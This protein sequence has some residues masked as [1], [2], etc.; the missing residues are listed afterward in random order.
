MKN[1]RAAVIHFLFTAATFIVFSSISVADSLTLT[2]G[3]V[4]KGDIIT[5][6]PTEVTMNCKVGK[7]YE[8]KKFA[9]AKIK[10]VVDD[11]PKVSGSGEPK[12]PPTS[13]GATPGGSASGG[14]ASKKPPSGAGTDPAPSESSDG[15][16]ADDEAKAAE[17]A[18][19]GDSLYARIKAMR[20]S[21]SSAAE[22]LQAVF[23]GFPANVLKYEIAEGPTQVKLTD[24]AAAEG[25]VIVQVKVDIEIDKGKYTIWCKGAKEAFSAIATEK[26][27]ISWNPK[28][29]GAVKISK[30]PA[31]LGKNGEIDRNVSYDGK[32]FVD[33][34]SLYMSEKT[35]KAEHLWIESSSWKQFT[36]QIDV[37]SKSVSNSKG[38]KAN[39]SLRDGIETKKDLYF[40]CLLSS[41]GGSLDVFGIPTEVMATL[42]D[43]EQAPLI[44]TDLLDEAGETIA[45]IVR[46]K[47]D[48]VTFVKEASRAK[49]LLKKNGAWW[50]AAP[51][52][53]SQTWC[54]IT[55]FLNGEAD[56]A[57]IFSSRISIPFWFSITLKD[58]PN[59]KKVDVQL[60]DKTAHIDASPD[61]SPGGTTPAKPQPMPTPAE[62]ASPLSWAE[63][64]EQNPDPK[65][66]TDADF[67][68]RITETKLPWRV[69]D[70]ASGIEML[71]VPPGKFVMGMSPGDKEAR[72]NEKP[73]HEVTITKAFYLG[74]TEVTQMQWMKVMGKNPSRFQSGSRESLIAKYIE[75]GLTTPQAK[76]KATKETSNG[77]EQSENPVE[78]VSWGDCQ[79]FCTKTGMKL[80][81]E[82][83]WE[84]ACR[85]GVLEPRY[86]ELDRIA[87]YDNNLQRA[88]H[89]VAQKA[90]N[91]LGFYDM[92]GNVGEFCLDI[93]GD[94][95]YK[96]CAEGVIDPTG[97][98]EGRFAQPRVL[99]G[100][101]WINASVACRASY[102]GPDARGDQYDNVGCRFARTAD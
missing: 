53:K 82:A 15:A 38:S 20:E 36:Q 86:G 65:V 56:R 31:P 49:A 32:E 29:G 99:R 40:V 57:R 48:P 95:Y 92:I 11:A 93:Y 33:C 12:T 89:S 42:D 59:C 66:V 102:R 62:T 58:L 45:S 46:P 10:S 1:S 70:K 13:T 30:K 67:L 72:D 35:A 7:T 16:K 27:T 80:P 78:N 5:N 8:V 52:L 24:Q 17:A 23:E 77:W 71:L 64:L 69:M 19:D 74:R 55:P 50:N 76:E 28:K 101:S 47:D 18:G 98:A 81:T 60:G 85:A 39:K 3:T 96:S 73:A 91:A 9:R 14:T 61:A 22:I 43:L 25:D 37:M 26:K 88:T 75:E 6:T 100:G 87:W 63:V 21:K 2:D 84:F 34:F 97:P 54:L 68:K 83:Q 90:P 44:S 94:D 4:I 79:A 51:A 41:A